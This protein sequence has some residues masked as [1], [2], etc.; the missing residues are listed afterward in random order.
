MKTTTSQ[1]TNIICAT[2]TKVSLLTILN[3][4]TSKGT[5]DDP[6]V[7]CRRGQDFTLSE[8]SSEKGRLLCGHSADKLL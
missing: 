3:T 2:L 1:A 6:R 7:S 8:D 4:G 5:Y